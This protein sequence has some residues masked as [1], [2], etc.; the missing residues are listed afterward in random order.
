MQG[1]VRRDPTKGLLKDTGSKSTWEPMR[2][3]EEEEEE[4]EEG[5]TRGEEEEGGW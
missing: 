2:T 3:E 1:A 4:E 5:V